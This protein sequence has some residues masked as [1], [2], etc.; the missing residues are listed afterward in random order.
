MM[1]WNVEDIRVV[2]PGES[3]DLAGYT[4]TL[5]EVRNFDGPNYQVTQG[6]VRLARNDHEI[7]TLYPEKRLY[8]V[9]GMPTTEAAIDNAV[10]RDIYVVIGDAQANGGWA[11]RSYY[12][13]LANWIWGGALLMALG[14]LLSLS[15]RRYRVA[16]GAR[17][18]PVAGVPAE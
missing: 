5:E 7:S 12:K 9:A 15:D 8:P 11:M 13:P 17:K 2:Q 6:V 18:A 4:L 3:Y 16:A 10:L 14:G 1:A